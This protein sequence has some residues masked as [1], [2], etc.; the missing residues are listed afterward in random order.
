VPQVLVRRSRLARQVMSASQAV[1]AIRLAV[2]TLDSVHVQHPARLARWS[3]AQEAPPKTVVVVLYRCAVGRPRCLVAVFAW[4]LD[5]RSVRPVAR[6]RSML[7]A[8]TAPQLDV[9]EQPKWL[10]CK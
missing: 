5:L 10:E 2:V 6:C 1:Q 3:S 4:L 8:V 7:E 9:Q